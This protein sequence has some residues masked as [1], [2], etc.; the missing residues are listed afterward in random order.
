MKLIE[1]IKKEMQD[2]MIPTTIHLTKGAQD[3]L[4]YLMQKFNCQTEDEIINIL[5]YY[6]ATTEY[7]NNIIL[8]INKP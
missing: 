4:R 6:A 3:N 5:L 1:M 8:D 7:T 2:S